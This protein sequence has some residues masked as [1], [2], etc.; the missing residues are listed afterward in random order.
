MSGEPLPCPHCGAAAELRIYQNDPWRY[1]YA[2]SMPRCSYTYEE[3]LAALKA[4][5]RR[6]R[7][8]STTLTGDETNTLK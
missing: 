7:D 2:C 6:D 1:Y 8:H 4:W 3:K 5:N